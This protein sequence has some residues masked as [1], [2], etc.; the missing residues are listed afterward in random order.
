MPSPIEPFYACFPGQADAVTAGFEKFKSARREAEAQAQSRFLSAM[1]EEVTASGPG[2][3]A[4]GPAWAWACAAFDPDIRYGY[5]P[6]GTQANVLLTGGMLAAAVRPQTQARNNE[7]R[8]TLA[9]I[10][11][12]KACGG[13]RR[14]AGVEDAVGGE[15][16]WRSMLSTRAVSIAAR[17]LAKCSDSAVEIV[18]PIGVQMVSE[19]YREQNNSENFSIPD[20]FPVTDPIAVLEQVAGSSVASNRILLSLKRWASDNRDDAGR[21][22]RFLAVL[23]ARNRTQTRNAWLVEM[24][25]P[26]ATHEPAAAAP[27]PFGGTGCLVCGQPVRRTVRGHAGPC[28]DWTWNPVSSVYECALCGRPQDSVMSTTLT[29]PYTLTGASTGRI[30]GIMGQATN[31]SR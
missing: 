23:L 6:P 24:V 29:S 11:A 30:S 2:N 31:V 9:A 26:C 20:R 4:I 27:L 28:T 18:G 14:A 22:Q 17:E 1:A 10:F 3:P 19:L 5:I 8:L 12:A 25:R 13:V 15:S 7:C 16:L 21:K